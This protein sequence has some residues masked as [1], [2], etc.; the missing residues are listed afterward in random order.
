MMSWLHEGV[1]VDTFQGD[2]VRSKTRQRRAPPLALRGAMTSSYKPTWTEFRIH[3]HTLPTYSYIERLL[4]R[5][6]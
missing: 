2:Q 5:R 6:D 3:P 4:S 1:P